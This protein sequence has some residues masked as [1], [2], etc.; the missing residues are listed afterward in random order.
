MKSKDKKFPIHILGVEKITQRP[1][2]NLFEIRYSDK[3]GRG[4]K[5]DAA[6][7]QP[8][9]KC[10]S[11]R[12]DLPDAVV[13]AALHAELQQLVVIREFRIPLGG[14]QYGFPAGL[15]EPGESI[16][17]TC[18]REMREET[19][20]EITRVLSVSPPL[21]SSSGMTDE[22]ITMV[23][24]ECAGTPSNQWNE[25]AED[26]ET[27]LISPDEAGRLC[28]DDTQMFDVKT[29]LVMTVFSHTGRILH[30]P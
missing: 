17:E 12:F 23:Y 5:W 1:H 16:R 4:R 24:A 19:G 6:S 11:G 29:W 9:A 30:A 8:D 18:I 2:V 15:L 3:N 22:S 27:L 21:Y 14:Y 28:A 10:V 7:R 13:I 20:L 26:I 25:S